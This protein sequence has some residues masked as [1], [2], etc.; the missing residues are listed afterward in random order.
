MK[1]MSYR[2]Y[3]TAAPSA[4][5]AHRLAAVAVPDALSP[6]F[7][8]A[9]PPMKPTPV[10]RPSSNLACAGDV[11]PRIAMPTSTTPQL[12]MAT[13]GNVRMPALR[14]SFSRPHP[15]GRPS[16]QDLD[17]TT[18]WVVNSHPQ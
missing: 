18:K 5:V 2:P 6:F 1:A 15:H 13:H 11:R 14:A 17:R 7:R 8:I 4:P 10:I 12:A 9:P 16:A 3:P